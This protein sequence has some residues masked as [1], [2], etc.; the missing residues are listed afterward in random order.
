MR[1]AHRGGGDGDALGR[2]VKR[3]LNANTTFYYYDGE[4]P[5]SE[6]GFTVATNI[7]GLGI[8][9]IVVRFESSNVYY[10]YQDHQGSITHVR[11]NN[12]FVEQYRYDAF[13]APTHL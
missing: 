2:C 13:G 5:I 10:F 8:D 3:T 11:N 7:Y 12:G 1:T 4:K 6:T 9:E